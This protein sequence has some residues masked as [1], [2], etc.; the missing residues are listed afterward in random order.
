ME[1]KAEQFHDAWFVEKQ[2]R[3]ALET[4]DT[5]DRARQTFSGRWLNALSMGR[6]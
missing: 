2:T 1:T 3:L 5:S 6:L 4:I